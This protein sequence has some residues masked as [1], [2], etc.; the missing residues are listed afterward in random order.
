[1]SVYVLRRCGTHIPCI[2][3]VAPRSCC[4][5]YTR[6]VDITMYKCVFLHIGIFSLLTAGLLSCSRLQGMQGARPNATAQVWAL[7]EFRGTCPGSSKSQGTTGRHSEHVEPSRPMQTH[8]QVEKN[9]RRLMWYSRILSLVNVN[10]LDINWWW[11]G[12]FQTLLARHATTFGTIK[13]NLHDLGR[14]VSSH[15]RSCVE[16]IA[17]RRL[18]LHLRP[19]TAVRVYYYSK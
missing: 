5:R 3:C 19:T 16:D 8:V 9:V 7:A 6:Y 18:G 14:V 4:W 12:I 17:T 10:E 11:K 2:V 15:A 1:M 13:Y